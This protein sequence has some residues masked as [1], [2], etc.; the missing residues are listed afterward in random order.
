MNDTWYP[1]N[2]VI[3]PSEYL[4]HDILSFHSFGN[5][6]SFNMMNFHSISHATVSWKAHV[7]VAVLP[8]SPSTTAWSLHEE[9]QKKYKSEQG[10]VSTKLR[11]NKKTR[12]RSSPI[13]SKHI[14][15]HTT[16]LCNTK[17]SDSSYITS[18]RAIP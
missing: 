1:I 18:L 17:I 10:Q 16:Y 13:K 12:N 9:G 8:S 6:F 4:M 7:V 11:T 15:H 5:I 3:Q 2:N 14:V